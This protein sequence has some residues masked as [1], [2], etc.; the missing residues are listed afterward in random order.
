MKTKNLLLVLGAIINIVGS[1]IFGMTGILAISNTVELIEIG[2][3][4]N[5]GEE[6][7][8]AVGAIFILL[9]IFLLFSAVIYLM[10]RKNNKFVLLTKICAI[11]MLVFG[12]FSLMSVTV[13]PFE[14]IILALICF[15]VGLIGIFANKTGKPTPISQESDIF[16][17]WVDK[18]NEDNSKNNYTKEEEN[19]LTRAQ[20]F[21]DNGFI[22]Y[23]STKELR[24]VLTKGINERLF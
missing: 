10:V 21:Y 12:F 13:M 3:L 24:T 18:E 2:N 5:F 8:K 4:E 6:L 19:E 22:T 1:F 7:V 16:T 9:A 14:S 15:G 17:N 23:Q 20:N 11:I